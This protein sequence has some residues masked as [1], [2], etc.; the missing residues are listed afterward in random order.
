MRTNNTQKENTP[1][2]MRTDKSVQLKSGVHK[3]RAWN[4]PS[5]FF[6]KKILKA[7]GERN[8]RK[9]IE[10]ANE[11]CK[12][13]RREGKFFDEILDDALKGDN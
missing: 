5:S 3:I 12:T 8:R 7:A 11:I 2:I 1:A 4:T 6:E 10:L 9:G 13:H